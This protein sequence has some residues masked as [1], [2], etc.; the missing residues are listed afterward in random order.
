MDVHGGS[1]SNRS[2]SSSR[3]SSSSINSNNKGRTKNPPLQKARAG[4][5]PQTRVCVQQIVRCPMR[6]I[7]AHRL[8]EKQCQLTAGAF[9][10]RFVGR[11][12]GDGER[13]RGAASGTLLNGFAHAEHFQLPPLVWLGRQ[14]G[15]KDGRPGKRSE[16]VSIASAA[17]RRTQKAKSK[18]P[19]RSEGQ[20]RK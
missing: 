14:E 2:R 17:N 13:T 8:F 15:E 1:R 16:D 20:R 19:S 12:H 9:H 18:E 3:S 6:A 4:Q 11:L 7:S 10:E 5:F